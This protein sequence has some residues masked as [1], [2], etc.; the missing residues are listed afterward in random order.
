MSLQAAVHERLSN[1]VHFAKKHWHKRIN[2][3]LSHKQ[4]NLNLS[5]AK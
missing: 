2:P 4:S 1:Q 3:N 5:Q